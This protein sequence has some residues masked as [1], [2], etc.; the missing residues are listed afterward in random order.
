MAEVEKEWWDRW[1]K[2]V[3]PNLF[4]YK[5]WKVKQEN[6]KAGELVML[7]YPG[8]FKDDYCIAKVTE[9]HPS[10]DGLVRQVSISYR[11]KNSRESP[12]VCKSKPLITEKVAIHRL[13]RLQLAD[14]AVLLDVGKVDDEA[15]G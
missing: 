11:K 9:V 13:H 2:Q 4:S 6:I 10:E 5:K 1:I 14:E 15:T 7:K 8:Q 12:T 3:L